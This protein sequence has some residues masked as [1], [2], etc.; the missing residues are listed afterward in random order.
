[1]PAQLMGGSDRAHLVMSSPDCFEVSYRINPWMEPERWH[2]SARQLADEA[3]HGWQQLKST[4]EQLGAAIEVQAPA[5][6]LPDMVFTAN[7]AMVLDRKVLLARFACAERRGEEAHDR[8]F[9]DALHARSVLDEIVEPPAGMLFEGAGDAQWDARREL[10][11]VGHGQRTSGGMHRVIS[12]IYSVAAEPLHLVDPRFYHLDTCLCLLP[13][14]EALFYPPAFSADSCARLR[15][16]I[17]P[18]LLIE[19]SHEDA[20]HLAVN[21]VGLGRD[22]V[23]CH[24]SARL[25]A[26]LSERGYR[27]HVVPLEPFNRSGGGTYCLTLRLNLQTRPPAP[28]GREA[29]TLQGRG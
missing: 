18:D 10:L 28:L 27:T 5:A 4:Y 12:E 2:P 1:M 22:V 9:F 7:A 17:G 19:A 14:G 6:G 20:H 25:R 15:G 21:A 11:W 29:A 26:V 24:A 16:R 23:M 13:G 3:R 8:A